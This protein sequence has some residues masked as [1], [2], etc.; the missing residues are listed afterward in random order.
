VY[1]QG[2]DQQACFADAADDDDF[3]KIRVLQGR[4]PAA[5][6]ESDASLMSS[7][8]FTSKVID[9]T[10]VAINPATPMKMLVDPA[11][12]AESDMAD[13]E[14]DD[15]RQRQSIEFEQRVQEHERWIQRVHLQRNVKEFAAAAR[16]GVH[17]RMLSVLNSQVIP[18]VYSINWNSRRLTVTGN[19]G[20][21]LSCEQSLSSVRE[22]CDLEEGRVYFSTYQLELLQTEGCWDCAA[23]VVLQDGKLPIAIIH[24]SAAKHNRFVT[25]MKILR[26]F[27]E[28]DRLPRGLVDQT[29]T[30]REFRREVAL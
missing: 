15:S 17:C 1:D 30:A 25:C 14:L 27:V 6:Q 23:V 26:L 5:D 20:L 19:D 7:P 12:P 21:G 10:L 13:I 18:A 4:F 29:T 11:T 3:S 16:R 2:C 22:I 9:A 8:S 28:A 24:E